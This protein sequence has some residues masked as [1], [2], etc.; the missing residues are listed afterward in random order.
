MDF[1]DELRVE[2]GKKSQLSSDPINGTVSS[3]EL[4]RFGVRKKTFFPVTAEKSWISFVLDPFAVN[5]CWD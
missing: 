3:T 4:S 1:Y 2:G 5:I